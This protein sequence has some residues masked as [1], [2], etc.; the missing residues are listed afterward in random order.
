M[1]I[2]GFI[3]SGL[4]VL[5]GF[6]VWLGQSPE[7][8]VYRICYPVEVTGQVSESLA[9]RWDYDASKTIN[10]FTNKA[11]GWCQYG[12]YRSI[13]GNAQTASSSHYESET[14]HK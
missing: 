13:Y 10:A 7:T 8:R 4:L 2:F 14:N 11:L 5:W 3:F 1:K 9:S 6:Y 12:V